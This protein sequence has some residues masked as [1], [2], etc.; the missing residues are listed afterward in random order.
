MSIIG[1]A[2]L[3]LG[4]WFGYAMWKKGEFSLGNYDEKL[5]FLEADFWGIALEPFYQSLLLTVPTVLLLIYVILK[6]KQRPQSRLFYGI[7]FILLAWVGWHFAQGFE[8]FILNAKDLAQYV[9]VQDEEYVSVSSHV[10]D[11]VINIRWG[12]ISLQIFLIG[13]WFSSEEISSK[14]QT[15]G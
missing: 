15:N 14:T 4:H 12:L 3:T 10:I 2:V 13:V 6:Y 1:Q 9:A 11:T 7:V 8:F 5:N